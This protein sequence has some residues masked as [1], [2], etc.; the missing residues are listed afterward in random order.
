MLGWELVFHR[1]HAALLVGPP[2]AAAPTG[3]RPVGAR[4]RAASE[5]ATGAGR[6]GVL[7]PRSASTRGEETGS[8]EVNVNA[9]QRLKDE[10]KHIGAEVHAR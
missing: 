4:A 5:A 1:V 2:P 3:C 6:H 10:Q 7:S 8:E 9:V